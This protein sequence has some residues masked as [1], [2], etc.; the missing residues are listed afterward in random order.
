MDDHNGDLNGA[1]HDDMEDDDVQPHPVNGS[2]SPAK[3]PPRKRTRVAGKS[4]RETTKIVDEGQR[5]G[6]VQPDEDDHGGFGGRRRPQRHRFEPLKYWENEHITYERTQGGVGNVM[7]VPKEVVRAK[8]S[9]VSGYT[10]TRATSTA[11]PTWRLLI[12]R[13]SAAVSVR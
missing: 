2:P 3:P 12:P 5:L 13:A 10:H 6:I 8:P 7:P 11:A 1:T 4:R 9:P